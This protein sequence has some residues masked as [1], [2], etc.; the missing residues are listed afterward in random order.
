MAHAQ[1]PDFVF[2]RNARVHLNR[3]GLHFSRLLAAELCA[4][5]LVILDTPFS[6]VVKGTGY[7]LHSPF[8]PSLPLPCVTVCHHIS[9]TLYVHC[10]SLISNMNC[11]TTAFRVLSHSTAQSGITFHISARNMLVTQNTFLN[12]T[13][14]L[15]GPG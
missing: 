5:A 3:R 2:H 10:L 14:M 1:K 7:P 8:F 9:N 11:I 15:C 4:Q 6:E 13:C 12:T